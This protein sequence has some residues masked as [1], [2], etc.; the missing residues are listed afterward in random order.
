MLQRLFHLALLVAYG[1]FYSNRD[2]AQVG[3]LLIV[4]QFLYCDVIFAKSSARLREWLKITFNA[5]ARYIYGISRLQHISEHTNRILGM[6]LDV[7]YDWKIC[8]MMYRLIESR[9]PEYLSDLLQFGWSTRLRI[10]I[11]PAHRTSGQVES[12]NS[13]FLQ[14]FASIQYS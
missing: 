12:Q 14:G 1:T 10:L 2:T 13:I 3:G 6:P 11:T 8:C 9:G 4:P 5:C 7:Y